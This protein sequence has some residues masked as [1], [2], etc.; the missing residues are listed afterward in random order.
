MPKPQVT[1]PEIMS[2]PTANDE[3]LCLPSFFP[4]QLAVFSDDVSKAIAQLYRGRYKLSRQEWRVLAALGERDGL[5]AKEIA[6]YSTLD[7][8][9]TSRAA[10]RL[11]HNGL[12][13]RDEDD[14]DRRHLRH[15]LTGKGRAV[16][17]EIVPL[18]R[19]RESYILSTLSEQEA[20]EL[21]RLMAKVHQKAL[22]LQQWG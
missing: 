6:E 13:I 7:K 9:Q 11:L 19:A 10:A 21:A 5:S 17:R 16:Y 18:V 2:D 3:R 14:S 1:D 12:I 22:E 20:K 8:T 4:Y 15:K